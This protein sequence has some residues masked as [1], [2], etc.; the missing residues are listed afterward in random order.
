MDYP[1]RR[2]AIVEGEALECDEERESRS[3]HEAMPVIQRLI[4]RLINIYG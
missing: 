1:D 2:G 3:C 4:I